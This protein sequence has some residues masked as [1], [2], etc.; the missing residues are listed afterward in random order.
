MSGFDRARY[1]QPPEIFSN[2][3]T[4]LDGS[5]SGSADRDPRYRPSGSGRGVPDD[6]ITKVSLY[7]YHSWRDNAQFVREVDGRTFTSQ[8]ETYP[9]P[10]GE[11]ISPVS[12]V[13]SI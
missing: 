12:I 3:G 6:Q 5:L 10:T 7:S 13:S 2:A 9:L 1:D 8:N 4:L 11:F